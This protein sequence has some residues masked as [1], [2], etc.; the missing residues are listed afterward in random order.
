MKQRENKKGEQANGT[1]VS[2]RA[3]KKEAKQKGNVDTPDLALSKLPSA[4]QG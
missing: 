3:R 4:E 1:D 2:S